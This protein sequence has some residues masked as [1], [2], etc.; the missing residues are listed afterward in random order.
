MRC[1]FS[2]CAFNIFVC[3]GSSDLSRHCFLWACLGLLS[4]LN[5]QAYAFLPNLGNFQP[6]FLQPHP[7]FP[8]PQTPGTW[9]LVFN[10]SSTGPVGGVGVPAL[11]GPLPMPT[12]PEWEGLPRCSSSHCLSLHGRGSTSW[13][14]LGGVRVLTPLG[15]CW[16]HPCILSLGRDGCPGWA[17]CLQRHSG[18]GG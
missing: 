18:D 14:F 17:C 6:L 12:W 5:L 16:C 3:L 1:C 11:S 7:P 2:L 9:T 4:F 10:Y 15:L 8:L 13:L